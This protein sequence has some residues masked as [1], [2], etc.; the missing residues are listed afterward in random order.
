MCS[1]QCHLRELQEK[2][3]ARIRDVMS[4]HDVI[5]HLHGYTTCKNIEEAR[6]YYDFLINGIDDGGMPTLMR[7]IADE[8]NVLI[9]FVGFEYMLASQAGLL[10]VL[11]ELHWGKG[12]MTRV[13]DEFLTK[14][15]KPEM[16]II[17]HVV[18]P[19]KRGF[20]LIR[21]CKFSNVHLY[22]DLEKPW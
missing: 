17:A 15:S 12:I 2:D 11:D 6:S 22:L 16:K 18:E 3:I 21:S 14:Y 7:C 10:C 8:N 9:G 5:Q 13:L 1:V 19:N 4:N 20:N